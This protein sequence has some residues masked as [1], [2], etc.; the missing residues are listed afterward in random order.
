MEENQNIDYLKEVQNNIAMAKKLSNTPEKNRKEVFK[1]LQ[2][3]QKIREHNGWFAESKIKKIDK[4]IIKLQ[5][6]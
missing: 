4:K 1:L 5:N 6:K 2:Q 3:Q